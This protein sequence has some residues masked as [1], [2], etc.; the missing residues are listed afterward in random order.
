[1]LRDDAEE[2]LRHGSRLGAKT[3]AKEGTM[4]WNQKRH[5]R[6]LSGGGSNRRREGVGKSDD[7]TSFH[8]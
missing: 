1:M 8:F 3:W 2:A 4:T 7:V 6:P 5:E